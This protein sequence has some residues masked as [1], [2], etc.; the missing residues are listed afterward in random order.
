M[1]D[2][3]TSSQHRESEL[4]TGLVGRGILA[5]RSPWLHEREGAAQ[6]LNLSYTL[7]DFSARDLNDAALPDILTQAEAEGYAGLN[8]TFPFK[9]A[10]I[11]HLDELSAGARRVGAV[12]SVCFSNGKR[13]GHNTDVTGFATSFQE[14]LPGAAKARVVQLGCGGAGS[15]TAH[16]LLDSGV[17]QLT[18]FDHDA[19]KAAALVAQL[20]QGH[21]AQR[22]LVGA[23]LAEAMSLADGLVNATPVGMAKYPGLPLPAKLIEARHWVAD[24][25]YFPLETA[26]LQEA[27]R[28]GCH[29]LDGSGMAVHQAAA[30]FGLFTKKTAD[31]ARML[32]SFIEFGSERQ[33]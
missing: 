10:V 22:A 19:S 13:T 1:T 17:D 32:Q 26:L 5:S 23:D 29:T 28:R 20:T 2:G 21:G 12:N 7:F 3:G 14:G 31:H 16:A 25:V 4:L 8:I 15:A 30:A 11:A 18:I 24:I 9:Q 27:T 6:G 33:T